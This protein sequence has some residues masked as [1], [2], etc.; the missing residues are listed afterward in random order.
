VRAH[1][2]ACS[3]L[4]AELLLLVALPVGAQTRGSGLSG[5]VLAHRAEQRMRY[6]GSVHEQSGTW[7]GGEGQLGVG[8]VTLRV[9]G[10]TGKLT[11]DTSAVNPDRSVRVSEASLSLWPAAWLDLGA[12]VAARRVESSA[13][14][15]VSRLF[16]GHV[17]L[18]IPLGVEG[19]TG[20]F[21]A[22]Y[23]PTTNVTGD[24]KLSLALSGELGFLYAPSRR[25]IVLRLSYRFERYDY[26]ASALGPARL[27]QMRTVVA[28]L[29]IQLGR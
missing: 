1:R 4:V 20:T 10:V 21:Q 9:S 22:V 8:P 19:L 7:F 27:E 12:D 18:A 2:F 3:T 11:G 14:T 24:E 16:G 25:G 28:G 13:S 29:G 6:L 26:A 5:V 17:G 15:V 23:Y